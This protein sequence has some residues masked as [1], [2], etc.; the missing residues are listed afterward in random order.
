[1]SIGLSSSRYSRL[2]ITNSTTIASL[3][4]PFT[5]GSRGFKPWSWML[6]NGAMILLLVMFSLLYLLDD[7]PIDIN[8]ATTFFVTYLILAL[9][10]QLWLYFHYKEVI[11]QAISH[12]EKCTVTCEKDEA[13]KW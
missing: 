2:N 5:Y 7:E 12:T 4:P 11:P 1:M 3:N 6:I 13:P 9:P 8:D 10:P